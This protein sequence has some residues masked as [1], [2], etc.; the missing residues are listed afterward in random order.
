L[1]AAKFAAA[2]TLSGLTF[3]STP[4]NSPTRKLDIAREEEF[5]VSEGKTSA[6]AG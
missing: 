3:P 5:G 6:A 2:E 4:R 1:D